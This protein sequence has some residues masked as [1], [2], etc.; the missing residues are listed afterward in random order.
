MRSEGVA[1]GTHLASLAGQAEV[2]RERSAAEL[3]DARDG[4]AVGPR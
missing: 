3:V 1:G 2:I 4:S